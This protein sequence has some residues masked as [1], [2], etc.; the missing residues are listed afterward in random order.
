MEQELKQ[1]EEKIFVSL[2]MPRTLDKRIR[3]AAARLCI[4]RSQLIREAVQAKLDSLKTE[5][6]REQSG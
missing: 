6:I 1:T 4:S 5:A 2:E 3:L